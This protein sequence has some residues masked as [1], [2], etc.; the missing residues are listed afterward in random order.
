ML[1]RLI[2]FS[3]VSVNFGYTVFLL[4]LLNILYG[5]R[6][7]LTMVNLIAFIL[8]STL[9][10]VLLALVAYAI[11]RV[12][13]MSVVRSTAFSVLLLWVA[14]WISTICIAEGVSEVLI[15]CIDGLAALLTWLVLVTLLKN[16]KVRL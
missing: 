13:R 16:S 1:K 8:V 14:F 7:P 3:I 4:P 12:A 15:L 6:V 5:K 9:G 11:M 10:G 2:L